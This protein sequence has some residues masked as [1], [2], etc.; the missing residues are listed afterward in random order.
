MVETLSGSY[1]NFGEI[2]A[3][4][5]KITA[6][7]FSKSFSKEKIKTTLSIITQL[8]P[9][10][11]VLE[12]LKTLR[13][14]GFKPIA[15]SNGDKN[16]LDVMKCS[17]LQTYFDAIY[18]LESVKKFKPHLDTY[19]YVLKEENYPSHK[20]MLIAAHAWDIVGAQNVGLQTAFIQRPGKFIYINSKS[21]EFICRELGEFSH[22][23]L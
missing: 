23:I 12:G 9:Y 4:T 1:S 6:Q 2:G 19:H 18:S 8:Q 14:K 5:L 10:P 3:A 11:D 15:L 16:T 20:A 21:P 13:Q 22:Q 7:S 17:G